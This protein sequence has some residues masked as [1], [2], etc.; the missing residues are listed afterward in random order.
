MVEIE[1]M[2][3]SQDISILIDSGASL[4]Y[5]SPRIVELCKLVS[6]KFDKSWLV[7]LAI[8]TKR[9]VTSLIKNCELMMND[10][11]THVDLNT[12]PLG[13]YDMVI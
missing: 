4:S 5:V 3:K 7:Q 1:G 11:I 2:I 9:K 6:E 10:F 8:D 13:S 12:L